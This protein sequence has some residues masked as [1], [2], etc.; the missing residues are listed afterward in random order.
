MPY[1]YSLCKKN[2]FD[3]NV[4]KLFFIFLLV[5]LILKPILFPRKKKVEEPFYVLPYAEQRNTEDYYPKDTKLLFA[6]NKCCKSCCKNLW[7]LP[8]DAKDCDTCSGKYIASNYMCQG[9]NGSGCVCVT[10]EEGD[11]LDRRANNKIYRS[12]TLYADDDITHAMWKS[13]GPSNVWAKEEEDDLLTQNGISYP[14]TSMEEEQEQE[15][16]LEHLR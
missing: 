3:F 6:D 9:K 5:F 12:N 10:K 16:E 13:D 14:E 7:P 1:S 15:M 4:I 11:Y 2:T 8:F